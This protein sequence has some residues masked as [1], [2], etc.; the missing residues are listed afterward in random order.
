MARSIETES[1]ANRLK[2]QVEIEKNTNNF[3]I[4]NSQKSLKIN[5]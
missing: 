4:G 2:D 5:V 3:I 1:E